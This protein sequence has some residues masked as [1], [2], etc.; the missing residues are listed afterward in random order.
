LP[1]EVANGKASELLKDL[2]PIKEHIYWLSLAETGIQDPDL[3]LIAQFS[4]LR[5]LRIENNPISDT[6]ILTLKNLSRLEIL[7]L[8][9]TKVSASGLGPLAEI[10]SL[11]SLF[12][13]NTAVNPH[14]DWVKKISS[15][16][17]KVIFGA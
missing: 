1:S 13:W 2:L 16:K 4:N 10:K 14:D 11:K 15:E 17:V 6:G 3:S 7:N 12:L 8:N 5:R 9:G